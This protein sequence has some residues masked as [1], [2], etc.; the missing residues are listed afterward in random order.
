MSLYIGNIKN[1]QLSRSALVPNE[2]FISTV[3][4]INSTLY[5]DILG[6]L[7]WVSYIL[8][9]ICGSAGFSFFGANMIKKY[10]FQ[11]TLPKPEE[12]VLAKTVLREASEK[13]IEKGRM[14]Y[15]INDDLKQNR[16]RMTQ[17]EAE[18]KKRIMSKKIKEIE[19]DSKELKEM[20]HVFEREGDYE[21]E[22]PLMYI[23]YGVLGVLSYIFGIYLLINNYYLINKYHGFTDN[24]YYILRTYLGQGIVYVIIVIFY[25]FLMAAILTGYD[26]FAKLTPDFIFMKYPIEEDKTWTD[27][28]LLAANLI[29]ICSFGI[30]V[31]LTRQ[32]KTIFTGT[33]LYYGFYLNL[34]S[35]YPYSYFYMNAYANIIFIIFYMVGFFIVFFEPAPKQKLDLL[36]DEKKKDLK[37]KQEAI[38]ENQDMF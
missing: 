20:L 34:P 31:L 5:L 7:G 37:D 11:P 14:V 17:V 22:N 33:G 6:L 29:M 19:N 4:S 13:I 26:K 23:M 1:L 21:N 9:I 35:V 3:F 16:H 38:N 2:E 30:I 8:V 10:L 12:Y 25:F 32:F 28:Y 15:S 27:N 18:T 36:I 24:T